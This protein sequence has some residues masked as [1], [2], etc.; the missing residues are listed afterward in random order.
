MRILP[1]ILCLP[2]VAC[3][4]KPTA[5]PSQTP[6]ASVDSRAVAADPSEA[7]AA[8]QK[9]DSAL[10]VGINMIQYSNLLVEAKPVVDRYLAQ[11]SGSD[12]AVKLGRSLQ[13]Y[14]VALDW[15]R[16]E[17]EGA[18]DVLQGFDCRDKV[19]PSIEA[20]YPDIKTQIDSAV[21]AFVAKNGRSP[22]KRSIAVDSKSILQLI[23]K[24]A[25]SDLQAI[26]P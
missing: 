15:W 9:V 8:L 25:G 3:A 2:L 26:N 11:D 10:D 16:C 19:L 18:S 5:Q 4:G 14:M 12:T 24:D 1:L 17:V 7:I 20:L 13:G 23:W 6:Q 21:I 22:S